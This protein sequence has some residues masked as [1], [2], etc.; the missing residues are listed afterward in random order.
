MQ[1]NILEIELFFKSNLCETPTYKTC[2][3][4]TLKYIRWRQYKFYKFKFITITYEKFN[5]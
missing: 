1:S 5:K 4:M 2:K 3:T